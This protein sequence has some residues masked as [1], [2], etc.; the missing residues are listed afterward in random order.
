MFSYGALLIHLRLAARSSPA[1]NSIG[2]AITTLFL[3]PLLD[4]LMLA[5]VALGVG[6]SIEPITAYAALLVAAGTAIINGTVA[7]VT[8]ARVLGVLAQV[9][10]FG[11][12]QPRFWSSQAFV[13]VVGA[14]A[15]FASSAIAIFFI[16]PSHNAKVLGLAF[17][18]LPVV[19]LSGAL[20]GVAA[21]L[22]AIGLGDP[23]L[24]AN[25]LGWPLTLLTGVLVPITSYPPVLGELG[26]VVPFTNAVAGLRAG[27]LSAAAGELLVMV[28]WMLIAALVSVWTVRRWRAGSV[29]E[30]LW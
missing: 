25:V 28:G 21:S 13:P 8:N 27:T 20:I 4:V 23:Y 30:S 15:T 6:G 22:C 9:L 19:I 11:L 26:R 3:V 12:W 7:S 24:V 2:T 29:R 14:S 10:Q 16:D 1:L 18:Y 5:A 17:S